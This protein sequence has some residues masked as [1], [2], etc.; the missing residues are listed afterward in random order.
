[1]KFSFTYFNWLIKH[2]VRR[3][4]NPLLI[5]L[6]NLLIG[7]PF[8]HVIAVK[9]LSF[10]PWLKRRLT[11]LMMPLPIQY[12]VTPSSLSDPSYT[13]S[14]VTNTIYRQLEASIMHNKR[15]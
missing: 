15:P 5:M 7:F 11:R 10:S 3:I 14:P 6:R 2:N 4:L 8:L 9:I 1:M 13:L 12:N